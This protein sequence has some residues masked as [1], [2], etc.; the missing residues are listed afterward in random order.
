ML[1]KNTQ[2][3]CRMVFSPVSYFVLIFYNGFKTAKRKKK[4][5]FPVIPKGLGSGHYSYSRL[6]GD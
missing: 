3:L 6:S 2:K 1:I 4:T 5:S